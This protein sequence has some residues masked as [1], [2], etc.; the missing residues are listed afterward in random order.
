[1]TQILNIVDGAYLENETPKPGQKEYMQ[2][3]M[4]ENFKKK[5][6]T[7][8]TVVELCWLS[9]KQGSSDTRVAL[10]LESQAPEPKD[11]LSSL[12]SMA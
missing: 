12:E 8:K 7:K 6:K 10:P 2:P 9:K 4:W 1:M 3:V 11:S 5:K